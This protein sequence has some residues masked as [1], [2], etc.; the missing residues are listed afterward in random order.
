MSYSRV[1]P[2]QNK[3]APPQTTPD[4][5]NDFPTL[6]GAKGKMSYSKHAVLT[7]KQAK[8]QNKSGPPGLNKS[9]PPGLNRSGPPGFS[10]AKQASKASGFQG[11]GTYS[12]NFKYID[13]PD[14]R[15]RNS[16][17]LNMIISTF[18]GGKSL[19]FANFKKLSNQF[20]ENQIDSDRYVKGCSELL[21]DSK[22]MNQFMPELIALLPN[23]P[24]QK[25]S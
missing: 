1:Q 12:G 18:G 22:K 4:L 10:Q 9:G 13:P 5:S 8:T 23:I 19:E 16:K 15:E 7:E 20:K 11:G 17:L 6:G 14:F 24:Q 3:K 21:D 2:P 25:V